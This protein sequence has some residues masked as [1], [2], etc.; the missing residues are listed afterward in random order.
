[1]IL[2]FNNGSYS[3]SDSQEDSHTE[4]GDESHDSEISQS[5]QSPET[6]E[7]DTKP[8]IERVFQFQ[9]LQPVSKDNKFDIKLETH[10]VKMHIHVDSPSGPHTPVVTDNGVINLHELPDGSK[11]LV[12]KLDSIQTETG[13]TPGIAEIYEE[14]LKTLQMKTNF[15]QLEKK[16]EYLQAVV[17]F[18]EGA[19]YGYQPENEEF[20]S[21][22]NELANE[23]EIFAG[24]TD[25]D[26]DESEDEES[27][28][29]V[30]DPDQSEIPVQSEEAKDVYN[31]DLSED[32]LYSQAANPENKYSYPKTPEIRILDEK[33]IRVKIY[34]RTTQEGGDSYANEQDFEEEI[35]QFKREVTA[36]EK[37]DI[38]IEEP[39]ES[40]GKDG[41]LP[42][43]NSAISADQSQ[44][45]S[46]EEKDSDLI[47]DKLMDK[48]VPSET[49]H[50]REI[51]D[52]GSIGDLRLGKDV[53]YLDTQSE[54][55]QSYR[56]P[57]PEDKEESVI[58]EQATLISE[59]SETSKQ[60]KNIQ[61]SESEGWTEDSAK[62]ERRSAR[63]HGDL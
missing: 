16:T 1:M 43:E 37:S 59:H 52:I 61:D 48:N 14:L 2:I 56:T 46:H 44:G 17:T 36:V 33:G 54:M 34:S 41:G 15:N 28:I 3:G 60:D 10:K 29:P 22:F 11:Q 26:V 49:L 50:N 23:L 27:E 57:K 5:E 7:P 21:L 18:L 13:A 63:G 47:S 9:R 20:K 30:H 6:A 40:A 39:V 8:Y 38:N 55:S 58:Q 4:M 42:K 62:N 19:Y 12:F 24:E 51:E 25:D 45:L 32:S 53:N 31:A 35:K